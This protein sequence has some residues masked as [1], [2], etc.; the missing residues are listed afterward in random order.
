M[1]ILIRHTKVNNRLPLVDNAILSNDNTCTL[2][3]HLNRNVRYVM[4]T[5]DVYN[6]LY[7]V[8][9]RRE[10]KYKKHTLYSHPIQY[11]I[12]NVCITV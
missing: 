5:L 1:Y 4:Y 9:C 12:Y 11:S 8:H 3:V 2:Q 10:G 7:W 6:A